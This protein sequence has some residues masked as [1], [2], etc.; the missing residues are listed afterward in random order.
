MFL[1]NVAVGKTHETLE[2]FIPAAQCPPVGYDSMTGLA[3]KDLNYP[4]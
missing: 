4:E 3:G 2:G 1:C